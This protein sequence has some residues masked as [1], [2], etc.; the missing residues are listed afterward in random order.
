M[1]KRFAIYLTDDGTRLVSAEIDM[2]IVDLLA[3]G[4]LTI[5]VIAERIGRSRSTVS[6]RLV[7][8]RKAKIITTVPSSDSRERLYIVKANR[9]MHSE[10][11]PS[12]SKGVFLSSVDKI[13]DGKVGLY[14]GLVESIFYGAVVGGLNTGPIFITIAEY[15][16]RKVAEEYRSDDFFGLCECLN[17]LFRSNG[18]GSFTM[19]V[20]YFVKIV[21]TVE[22]RYRNSEFKV[23]ETIY[24]NIIRSAMECNSGKSMSIIYEPTPDLDRFEF[25]LHFEK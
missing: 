19:T 13:L 7:R 21:F 14:D 20:T 18:I 22:E 15:I 1:S 5:G 16:G 8:L 23:M 12:D 25:E 17:D 10:E 24:R 4:G 9:L 11:P 2:D 3:Q 6:A